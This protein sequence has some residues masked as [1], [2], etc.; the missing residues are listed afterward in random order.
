M[1]GETQLT[2]KQREETQSALGR[3]RDAINRGKPGSWQQVT[4]KLNA[5]AANEREKV[6]QET[7]RKMG[8]LGVG[9]V[10]IARLV[11]RHLGEPE[12]PTQTEHRFPSKFP[13][14]EILHGLVSEEAINAMLREDHRGSTSDPGT[15]FW[16]GR[17][18]H[19]EAERRKAKRDIAR[20]LPPE[21][22][23]EPPLEPR[24][25]KGKLHDGKGH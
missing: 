22:A 8:E 20:E 21:L 5:H 11:R 18:K 23:E 6:T 1:A 14:A 12:E 4:D 9:G 3:I 16:I 15:D 10:K 25:K 7:V 2:E 13:A 19:W 17:A 24:P